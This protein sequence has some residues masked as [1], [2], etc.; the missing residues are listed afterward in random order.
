MEL[1]KNQEII[2]NLIFTVILSP[3]SCA[4]FSFLIGSKNKWRKWINYKKNTISMFYIFAMILFVFISIVIVVISSFL[5]SFIFHFLKYHL[6]IF[7]FLT[8]FLL[9]KFISN[10]KT[11]IAKIL[12]CLIFLI[13]LFDLSD[14]SNFN[15]QPF[16]ICLLI[17]MSL[18]ISQILLVCYDNKL[19]TDDKIPKKLK[20]LSI[21]LLYLIIQWS[22][23]IS[24]SKNS[25]L[26]NIIYLVVVLPSL[27]MFM[28][29]IYTYRS[30]KCF[31]SYAGKE[32]RYIDLSKIT[33]KGS[34]IEIEENN[35]KICIFLDK[36]DYVIFYGE[37]IVESG[38]SYIY[39]G[40]SKIKSMYQNLIHFIKN[41][42]QD[43]SINH[44]Q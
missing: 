37:P 15:L 32:L 20:Q 42:N 22:I 1:L 11:I 29:D 18:Q 38:D 14:T 16:F 8:V 10:P 21:V 26:F 12:A 31:I 23:F 7:L 34:Y 24:N 30:S 19:S 17:F 28:H 27:I 5:S 36:I 33:R 2:N 13:I 4:I 41:Q 9:I 35:S 6:T 43:S 44:N 3:L 40:L 39:I 25:Y